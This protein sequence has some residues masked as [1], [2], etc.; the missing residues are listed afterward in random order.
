VEGLKHK[1]Y[2]EQL[3]ELKLFTLEKGRFKQYLIA[4]YNK[5]KGGCS[6]VGVSF[7]S[8]EK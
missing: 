4:L 5:L 3:R 8:Q 7:F 1:S 6:K 2:E